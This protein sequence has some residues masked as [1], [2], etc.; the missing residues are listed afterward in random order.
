MSMVSYTKNTIGPSLGSGI[1]TAMEGAAFG[2]LMGWV[3][4]SGAL[5]TAKILG[6]YGA[7][8]GFAGELLTRSASKNY[9][10]RT[11]LTLLAIGTTAQVL[12]MRRYH[13]IAKN[14]TIFFGICAAIVNIVALA[15]LIINIDRLTLVQRRDLGTP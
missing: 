4:R 9:Q 1:K 11:R 8:I 3:I 6:V 2:L 13:I 5:R 12:L 10:E 14:G 15:G 7:V